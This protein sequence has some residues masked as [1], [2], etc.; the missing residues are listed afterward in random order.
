MIKLGPGFKFL[1]G[2]WIVLSLELII[3]IGERL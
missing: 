2:I 3:Y 1:I